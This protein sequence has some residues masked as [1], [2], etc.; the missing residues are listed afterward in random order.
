ME[1]FRSALLEAVDEEL[2]VLGERSRDLI[3]QHIESNYHIKREETP[4]RLETYNNVLKSLLGLKVKMILE[5]MIARNLY[6]RL[7]LDFEE[8]E[9]WALAKYVDYAKRTMDMD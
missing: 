6:N 2:L 4:D 5:K 3:Y 7:G 8:H 9:N 1:E